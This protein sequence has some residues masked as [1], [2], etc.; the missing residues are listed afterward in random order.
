MSDNK[1]P[2]L[3]V[4]VVITDEKGQI[5]LVKR[6]HPPFTDYWALPGGSIEYGETVEQTALREAEEETG[7]KVRVERLVG[8]YSDPERDPRGHVISIAVIAKQIG[9]ELIAGEETKGVK[10]FDKIPSELAFDHKK[11]LQDAFS[12]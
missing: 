6:R 8:V 9:G 2:V 3:A 5:V 1:F 10:F 7:L 11:I 12:S 4:D